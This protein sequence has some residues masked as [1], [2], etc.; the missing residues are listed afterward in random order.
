MRLLFDQAYQKISDVEHYF[1]FHWPIP[2]VVHYTL[3][4]AILVLYVSHDNVI[5]LPPMS[6]QVLF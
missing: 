6:L 3:Q 1:A 2:E 5:E 4:S